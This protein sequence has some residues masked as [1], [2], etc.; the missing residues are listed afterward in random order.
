MIAMNKNQN[1]VRLVSP[2]QSSLS[3]NNKKLETIALRNNKKSPLHFL[4]GSLTALLF[5]WLSLKLS[6]E[7]SIYFALHSFNTKSS[8]NIT[9]SVALK[10][11]IIGITYLATFSFSFIGIGLFVIF[12]RSV[13]LDNEDTTSEH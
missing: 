6:Q 4:S 5:G 1:F 7:M 8:I 13:L 3:S 12:I 11:L 2:D 9:F 10:T